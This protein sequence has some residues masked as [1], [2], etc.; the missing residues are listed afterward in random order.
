M[1][2][3]TF[4]QKRNLFYPFRHW[5]RWSLVHTLTQS[6]TFVRNFQLTWTTWMNLRLNWGTNLDSIER[7]AQ[8]MKSFMR[9]SSSI[10]PINIYICYNRHLVEGPLNISHHFGW[11]FIKYMVIKFMTAWYL[12]TNCVPAFLWCFRIQSFG[13]YCTFVGDLIK[14]S[15]KWLYVICVKCNSMIISKSSSESNIHYIVDHS[16]H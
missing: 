9:T 7:T 2:C 5:S 8:W 4:N 15:W 1:E 12:M 10:L 16:Y 3:I 14:K 6:P 13:E 11:V